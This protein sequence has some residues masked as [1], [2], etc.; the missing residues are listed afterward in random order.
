MKR[1]TIEAI[2]NGYLIAFY[3]TSNYRKRF[4]HYLDEVLR[5]T[6][7]FL[8]DEI[9]TLTTDEENSSSTWNG[10]DAIA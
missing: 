4:T 3:E 9:R 2:D 5:L 8:S 10:D 6:D 7:Q 1:V